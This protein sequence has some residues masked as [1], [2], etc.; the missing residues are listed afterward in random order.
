M[1]TNQLQH[2]PTPLELVCRLGVSPEY[3]AFIKRAVNSHY[4]LLDLAKE[5]NRVVKNAYQPLGETLLN[6]TQEADKVIAKAE[7][8]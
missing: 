1:N 8:A 2:M 5:L 6:L 7:A 4:N 3:A